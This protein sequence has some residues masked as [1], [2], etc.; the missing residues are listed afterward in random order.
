MLF[1]CCVVIPSISFAESVIIRVGTGGTEGTYFPIG[2]LIAKAISGPAGVNKQESFYESELI[3]IPQRGTGAESNVQ[4]VSQ[5]LLEAGLAQA[6]VVH[7]A[8][9]GSGPFKGGPARDNLRALATLYVESVHLIAR[10]DANITTIDDLKNKR[11]SLDEP[12]SGTRLDMVHI[13]A[14][15]GMNDDSI[16]AVYLKP[17]DA[18]DRLQ[19]NE[20]DAFFI[21]AGFPIK[22]VS[23]LVD[24]GQAK[25]VSIAGPEVDSLIEEYPFFSKNDIPENTYKNTGHVETIGVPAQLIINSNIDEKLVY[26]ITSM[27]WSNATKKLLDKG[28][29]KGAEVRLESAMLGMNIPL[30]PGAERFYEEQ[31]MLDDQ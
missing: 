4:D 1:V 10:T 29:P 12:G 3:A 21:I 18:I 7:W 15:Y 22:A 6:D 14:A 16:N 8:F 27:L 31:G 30:H 28:H 20:L 13:L 19:R 24:R 26:N 23:D 11:V 2:S 17:A 5:G 9:T 25:V